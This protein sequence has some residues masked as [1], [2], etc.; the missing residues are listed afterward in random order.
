MWLADVEEHARG[1]CV[2]CSICSVW[3][4]SPAAMSLEVRGAL[5]GLRVMDSPDYRARKDCSVSGCVTGL[6]C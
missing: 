3:S 1:P 4:C 5:G 2:W 6:A